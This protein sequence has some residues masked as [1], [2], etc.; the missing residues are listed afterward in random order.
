MK[1]EYRADIDG[2][3]AVAVVA[4]IFF[5]AGFDCFQGGYVGVDIFFVISGY[6]ITTI[7][8]K[9]IQT[10]QFSVIR[11]YERRIRRIFPA[12]FV[13]LAFTLITGALLFPPA[14]FRELGESATAVALFVSNLFFWDQSGYFDAPAESKPL[15]HTWSLAVE[16]QYYIVFPWLLI[17][18]R[19]FFQARYALWFGA[20]IVASLVSSAVE[21]DIHPVAAFYMAP[22][23]AW[24]LLL[25][26]F[27]ALNVIP[28][29]TDKRL[30]NLFASLGFLLITASVFLYT[31][32]TPFPGVSAL[33]P[34]AGAGLLIYCGLGG[35]TVVGRGLSAKPVVFL[36]LLSYSLYLWH[37]PFLVFAK[38][39]T[40]RELT[41][42]EIWTL[43][44][45][46][47]LFSI[48]SWRFVE[49]PF[50]GKGRLLE[51]RTQLFGVA[52]GVMGLAI[53]LSLWIRVADGFPRRFDS[54][55]LI[56]E[57]REDSEWKRWAQ[58]QNLVQ[59]PNVG[60]DL[61]RLGSD[62][63][64]PSFLLWGDSHALALATAVNVSATKYRVA[65]R[66]ATRVSCPPFLGI[67]ETGRDLSCQDFN[68]AVLQYI[69][70]R[71][72]LT[73]ILLASRW[74]LFAEGNF[75]KAEKKPGVQLV[76]TW[77]DTA[78]DAAHSTLF[79]VGLTRAVQKLLA[80]NRKVVLI[81]PVP[82][83]GYQV[84][85]AFVIALRTGRDLN[86]IIGPKLS[87]Y[88]DRNHTVLKT[89]ER[90]RK[91]DQVQVV[92][93]WE[94]MCDTQL[95]RV[96]TNGHVLYRD[97]DH[98][99][100]F[101]ARYVSEVFDQVFDDISRQQGFDVANEYH[102]TPEASVLSQ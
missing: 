43:I 25:G 69:E 38:Y 71:P 20:L 6:L 84:P 56:D 58:C 48:L 1:S 33:L 26:G 98:L 12:L 54:V 93:I 88:Q 47:L 46:T 62:Q 78:K 87:E 30:R 63:V 28:L 59:R 95:C 13:V 85:P 34:T 35:A 27:I 60:E 99:S 94:K 57:V 5:H 100:T 8:L 2:L 92:H 7:I 101:G 42:W 68:N 19:R 64:A 90:L 10:R 74:A 76:D 67:T 96:V 3:R 9:E 65:G 32:E 80:L 21:V 40:I 29:P 15:L 51:D 31:S 72:E 75:H 23:R 102:P 36:G 11:F 16:E 97:S 53:G 86:N 79:D 17:V 24:E 89:F 73:T 52:G 50:R 49:Q 70:R 22:T 45:L 37:W 39:F 4:V 66:V 55:S 91:P 77:S 82:E 18:V 41:V 44:L 61:C 81:G 14:E 83:V